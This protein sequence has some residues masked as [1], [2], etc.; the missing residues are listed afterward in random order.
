MSFAYQAFV[1]FYVY[2]IDKCMIV[3]LVIIIAVFISDLFA[4]AVISHINFMLQ[5]VLSWT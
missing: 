3:F 2:I 4:S 5:K 1:Q